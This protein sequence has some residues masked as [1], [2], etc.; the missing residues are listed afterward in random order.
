MENLKLGSKLLL[1]FIASIIMSFMIFMSFT[2]IFS[3][4]GTESIGYDVWVT[5]AETGESSKAYTHYFAD[6]DDE[7]LEEYKS[8]YDTVETYEVR[9]DFSGTP[10]IACFTLAQIVSLWLFVMF[11]PYKLFKI[12]EADANKVSCGR[13]KQDNLKGFKIGLVPS[14]LNIASFA[15]LCLGKL[16]VMGDESLTAYRFL[17]YHMYGYLR[18]IFGQAT[19]LA[20]I[21]WSS[22][23][24][25]LLPAVLTLSLSLI[26]YI[27]G[28]K[29]INLYE[30][31]VYESKK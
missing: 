15:I 24:L 12:G 16:G 23:V 21:G 22:V 31:T 8:L 7:K 3:I 14:A 18:L 19:T 25:A 27:L 6:G 29:K 26:I 28:F 11:V 9:S 17:N 5:D 20:E 10:M 4:M 2:A 1:R 30:K 13:M